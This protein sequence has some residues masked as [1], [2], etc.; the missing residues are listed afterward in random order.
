MET[1]QYRIMNLSRQIDDLKDVKKEL[2]FQFQ[3]DQQNF[4][5]YLDLKMKRKFRRS[6]NKSIKRLEKQLKKL[7]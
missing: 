7:L 4:H 2:D 5:N 6:V 1:D 3:K